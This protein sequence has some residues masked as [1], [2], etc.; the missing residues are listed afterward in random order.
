MSGAAGLVRAVPDEPIPLDEVLERW[1]V[2]RQSN[3]SRFDDCEL[4]TLF[5]L[6]YENGWSTS[7]QARGTIE[8][9]V[10]A[11]CLREMQRS[12]SETIPV[13]VAVS[14]LIEKLRQ[15]GVP[16]ED[17]VRVPLRELRD[18]EMAVKKWA[19]DNTFTIRNLIDVERRLEGV[20]TYRDEM[21]GMLVERRVSGQLDVLIAKEPDEAIVLDWKGT[22]AL[23][24]DRDADN[25]DDGGGLSYHGY[26]QQRLYAIL[27]MQNFPSIQAVTLREFYHRRS[28]ARPARLTRAELPQAE[29]RIALIVEAF[30]K[31]LAAGAPPRLRIEDLEAHGHWKPSPGKHCFN[32]K[33]AHLCPIDDDYKDG[34]IR[35]LEDAERAAETRQKARSIDK[36]VTE[37][38]KNWVDLHGP[39]PVKRAKGRLVLGYRKVK[40]GLR[41]EEFT[42]TGADKPA[43]QEAYDPNSPLVRAMKDSVEEA[44]QQ[45]QEA[46]R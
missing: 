23:P 8:H 33:K 4:T 17:R 7:P 6:R 19:W 22:W 5:A 41:F 10:F 39:I 25:Q 24:P 30:D 1:P 18:M 38:C 13:E 35:T 28:K 43:T 46:R 37:K 15:H 12:D 11:E 3:L 32:C 16:P 36:T 45:R 9:R 14:I 26:F 31:A 34:A 27:V 20:L 42:P 21:T 2:L 29:E 40:N 44:R